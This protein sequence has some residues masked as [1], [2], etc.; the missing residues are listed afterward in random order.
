M[1]RGKGTWKDRAAEQEPRGLF[2][3]KTEIYR[4]V[5]TRGVNYQITRSSK[6]L[7][8]NIL[9]KPL[10]KYIKICY[11]YYSKKERGNKNGFNDKKIKYTD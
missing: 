10:D 9:K 1:S 6:I 8:R 7:L 5:A 4:T 3:D 11:N 2:G